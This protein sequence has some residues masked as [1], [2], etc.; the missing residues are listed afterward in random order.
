MSEVSIR[1]DLELLEKQGYLNRIHG[2]A[3]SVN[4]SYIN[5][6]LDERFTTN[7]ASKIELARAVAALVT[8][9]DTIMYCGRFKARIT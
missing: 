8:D 3:V 6:D 5:M 7:S 1:K 4:K 9:N 2:G